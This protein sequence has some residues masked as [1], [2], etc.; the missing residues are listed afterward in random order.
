MIQTHRHGMYLT[1][2]FGCLLLGGCSGSPSESDMQSALLGQFRV[3]VGKSAEFSEFDS[4]GCEADRDDAFSCNVEGTLTYRVEFGGSARE[5]TQEI[6]GV[7]RF[8][9]VA[10]KWSVA[11]P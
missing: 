5:G 6:S 4:S 7:Y 1:P 9:N 10:G 11:A 3:L 8:R 2:I